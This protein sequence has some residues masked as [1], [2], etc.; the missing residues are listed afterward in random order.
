MLATLAMA[1][2]WFIHTGSGDGEPG[3][4]GPYDFPAWTV[5]WV[6]NLQKS[7]N[8][9]SLGDH[10][11]L[12]LPDVPHGAP[13][14]PDPQQHPAHHPL[15]ETSIGPIFGDRCSWCGPGVALPPPAVAQLAR[16]RLLWGILRLRQM[17]VPLCDLAGEGPSS[18]QA[19]SL[20]HGGLPRPGQGLSFP[21]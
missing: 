4:W 14:P 8:S 9:P 16:A 12:L 13:R 2:S 1:N 18:H 11:D 21:T 7:V 5:I 20:P 17:V 10:T 15:G 3:S 19:P 6:L